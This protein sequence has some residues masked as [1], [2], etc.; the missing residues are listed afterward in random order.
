MD[1]ECTIIF[2]WVWNWEKKYVT[3]YE[4]CINFSA[5]MQKVVN[6]LIE[7]LYIQYL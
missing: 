7:F 5:V 2:L 4:K 3:V 1:E 6:I